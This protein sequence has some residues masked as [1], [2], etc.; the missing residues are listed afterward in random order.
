MFTYKRS[1][2]VQELI[3]E[4]TSG[5]IQNEL[6][7]PRLGFVTVTRVEVTENLRFAKIY[8]SPMGPPEEQKITYKIITRA[9]SYIRTR[10]GKKMRI[11]YLPEIKF[12]WDHSLENS[13][14][15]N[16]VLHAIEDGKL[17]EE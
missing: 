5:I 13:D 15:I 10:L 1:D 14:R 4:Q 11:K 7:D 12:V 9:T 8:V 6:K 16:R 3:L 17:S 2:R